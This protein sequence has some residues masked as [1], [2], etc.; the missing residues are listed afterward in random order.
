MSYC[1]VG[2]DSDVYALCIG[3]GY[4]ITVCRTD[5]KAPDH[6]FDETL[7][8]FH[9]RLMNLKSNG[10]KVPQRVFDR[11]NTEILLLTER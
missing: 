8:R 9:A 6:Y 1:R 3:N 4:E 10:W 5:G 2:E 11:I 7:D